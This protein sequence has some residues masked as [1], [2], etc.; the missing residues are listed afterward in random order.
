[1][2]VTDLDRVCLFNRYWTAAGRTV[3]ILEAVESVEAIEG[4][5]GFDDGHL[6]PHEFD[7]CLQLGIG[8]LPVWKGAQA[9]RLLLA[10]AE[11][12]FW[13]RWEGF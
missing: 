11:G 4:A 1:M 13:A 10:F 5:A 9:H 3:V 7:F 6:L 8:R 2:P 12:R